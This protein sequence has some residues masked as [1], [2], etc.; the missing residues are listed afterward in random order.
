MPFQDKE[1]TKKEIRSD[2]V[3]GCMK[4]SMTWGTLRIFENL[5]YSKAKFYLFFFNPEVMACDDNSFIS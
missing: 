1:L 2:L 4:S 5:P 3:L